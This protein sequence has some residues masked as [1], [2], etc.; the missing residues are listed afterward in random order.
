MSAR[1]ITLVTFVLCIAPGLS[2][3]AA[4]TLATSRSVESSSVEGKPDVRAGR[5]PPEWD[6][7]EPRLNDIRRQ[8]VTVIIQRGGV[9]SE[10]RDRLAEAREVTGAVRAE[11]LAVSGRFNAAA[12]V[13]DRVPPM[14]ALMKQVPE[15]IYAGGGVVIVPRQAVSEIWVRL[16][17][18]ARVNGGFRQSADR[19]ARE[20]VLVM[21]GSQME[22][23]QYLIDL[24]RTVHG[25]DPPIEELSWELL[26]SMDPSMAGYEP[27]NLFVADGVARVIAVVDGVRQRPDRVSPA[28][29]GWVWNARTRLLTPTGVPAADIHRALLDTEHANRVLYIDWRANLAREQLRSLRFAVRSYTMRHGSPPDF[30]NAGWGPLVESGYLAEPIANPMLP[31]GNAGRIIVVD[32]RGVEGDAVAMDDAGWVWNETDEML[33]AAGFTDDALEETASKADRPRAIF[34]R[35]YLVEQHAKAMT[36]AVGKAH[37]LRADED[38]GFPPLDELRRPGGPLANPPR[39]PFNGLKTIQTATWSPDARAT[40]NAT[41]WNYDP[42]AGIVWA[43]TSDMRSVPARAAD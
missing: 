41:G 18:A 20:M 38:A 12:F 27:T 11:P 37:L 22:A 21:L 19:R 4:D 35:E 10:D 39:N 25:K 26:A 33:Y 31:I 30:E 32:G 17:D 43:N 34:T 1:H 29:A 16:A 7:L 2:S 9:S 13:F 5:T 28:K 3:V 6:G 36:A 14:V 40:D 23:W 42:A 8:G 24:Y 15:C